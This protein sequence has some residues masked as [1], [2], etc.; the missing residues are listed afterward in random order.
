MVTD[1]DGPLIPE[2]SEGITKVAWLNEKEINSAMKNSYA[3]IKA[4]I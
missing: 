1:Y 4:L 3:N 2:E